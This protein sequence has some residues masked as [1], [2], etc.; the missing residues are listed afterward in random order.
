M[1]LFG[2]KDDKET[3]ATVKPGELSDES[4]V[5]EWLDHP[6]GGAIFRDMLKQAGQ[7]ESVLRLVRR[8]L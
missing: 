3:A 4:T 2:K 6:V 7:D 1:G 8:F 5:A